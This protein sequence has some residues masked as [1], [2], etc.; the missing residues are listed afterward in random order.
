M[1]T[2]WT[3]HSTLSANELDVLAGLDFGPESTPDSH[4]RPEAS[5]EPRSRMSQW[6]A[7]AYPDLTAQD[8]RIRATVVA[9]LTVTTIVS[10]TL[11]LFGFTA[12]PTPTS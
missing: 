11:I 10:I 5:L 12:L 9:L 1:T 2:H 6:L 4:D 3:E 8:R 7:V